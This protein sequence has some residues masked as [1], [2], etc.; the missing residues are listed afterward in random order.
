[1]SELPRAE[2]L[3]EPLVAV[4][5]QPESF[6]SHQ[7]PDLTAETMFIQE[8]RTNLAR[9]IAV[10]V[11]GWYPQI[12]Q[13]FSVEGFKRVGRNVRQMVQFQGEWGNFALSKE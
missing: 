6:G 4:I 10:V 3:D 13:E 2:D 7:P 9:N 1:L 11:K 5:Q 12:N 8:I